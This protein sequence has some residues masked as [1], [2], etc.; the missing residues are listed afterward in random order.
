MTQI[1]LPTDLIH[2]CCI[3]VSDGQL[4]LQWPR[5]LILDLELP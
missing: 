4:V 1:K 5:E 2:H 3:T